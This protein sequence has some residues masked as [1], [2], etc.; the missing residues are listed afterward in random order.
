MQIESLSLIHQNFLEKKLQQLNLPFSEY[1]FANLYLFRSLHQYE[2]IHCREELFIRGMT[3]DKVPF[4]MLTSHPSQIPPQSIQEALKLAQIFFPIPDNWF[5]FFNKGKG[6]ASF[7]EEDSDYLY[8]SSTLATYAGRHLDGKRNLVKRFLDHHEVIIKNLPEQ[9]EDALGI[10]DLWQAEQTQSISET[11]YLPCKEALSCLQ[12]LHLR[13]LIVY[14]N[15]QPAGFV[16]GERMNQNFFAV[17]FSK[18]LH[19]FPGIYPF[20]F[21]EI[22]GLIQKTCLWINLEQDLG[23][24][25][26]RESKLS[27]HPQLVAK[28][29]RLPIDYGSR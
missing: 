16:I 22:A 17:H 15:K 21:R 26:L 12:Q 3:R 19:A 2:V 23:I 13:G 28:K 7:N 4:M 9:F 5:N 14:V 10:L 25:G 27:Y 20:L 1:S 18:G 8:K 24:P 29:W 6:E 11:D